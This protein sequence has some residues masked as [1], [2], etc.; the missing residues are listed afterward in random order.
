MLAARN[1]HAGLQPSSPTPGGSH[2]A[3]SS[4]CPTRRWIMSIVTMSPTIGS[5][6]DEIG[7]E[8]AR[9]RGYEF[10][11]REIIEKAAAQF[12]EGV[13]ELAHATEEKPPLGVGVADPHAPCMPP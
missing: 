10:A 13:M 5:L 9:A 7:R 4:A 1:R 6:G 2:R 12:G 3:I 8:V 11:D